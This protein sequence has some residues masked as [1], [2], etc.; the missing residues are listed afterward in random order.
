MSSEFG[1]IL[2]ELCGS[3]QD[4][5]NTED[6]FENHG[7]NGSER[8]SR[9]TCCKS[10]Y[11][12]VNGQKIVDELMR[13]RDLKYQGGLLLGDLVGT[14]VLDQTTIDNFDAIIPVLEK[15]FDL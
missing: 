14:S 10:G 6:Y 2:C 8:L 1:L 15:K 9:T 3:I 5:K 11:T 13:I 7:H 4:E 12:D